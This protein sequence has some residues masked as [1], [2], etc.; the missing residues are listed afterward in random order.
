MQNTSPDIHQ[1]IGQKMKNNSLFFCLLTFLLPFGELTNASTVSIQE[2][3]SSFLKSYSL[4]LAA[5]GFRSEYKI[6]NIDPRL[7]INKCE[8][9][10]IFSFIR[11]PLEQPQSTLLVTCPSLPAWKIY[12]STTYKIFGMVVSSRQFVPRG[13]IIQTSALELKEYQINKINYDSFSSTKYVTGMTAKRAIKA[14]KIITP[15]LLTPPRLIKRGDLVTIIASNHAISIKMKG[16]ALSHGK[17]GEQISIR[18]NQSKRIIKGT[19][20]EVGRVLV[21]L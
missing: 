2:Q 9:S 6:G 11:E 14:N 12:L 17:M 18:N 7:I 19:V 3:A 15:N 20:V 8:T 13:T 16:T 21:T 4:E 1:S 10:Y 5:K